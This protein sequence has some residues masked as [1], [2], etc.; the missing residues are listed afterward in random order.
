[1]QVPIKTSFITEDRVCDAEGSFF[2]VPSCKKGYEPILFGRFKT[3]PLKI[4]L[5]EYPKEV[6]DFNRPSPVV[7]LLMKK[8][9]YNFRPEL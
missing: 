5:P 1:M 3:K 2:E 9:S 4:M 6:P 7:T 8:K